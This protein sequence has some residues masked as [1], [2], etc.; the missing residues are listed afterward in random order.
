MLADAGGLEIGGRTNCIS[1]VAVVAKPYF[2]ILTSLRLLEVSSSMPLPS[3]INSAA[4]V[5]IHEAFEEV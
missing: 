2:I 3:G 4:V 5:A 1:V